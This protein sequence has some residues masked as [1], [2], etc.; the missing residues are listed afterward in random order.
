[1]KK[2][3]IIFQGK[4][5]SIDKFIRPYASTV[6]VTIGSLTV[7]SSL[8]LSHFFTFNFHRLFCINLFLY[9]S[10]LLGPEMTSLFCVFIH[11]LICLCLFVYLYLYLCPYVSISTSFAWFHPLLCMY[12]YTMSVSILSLYHLTVFM[13]SVDIYLNTTLVYIKSIHLST[14]IYLT[15]FCICANY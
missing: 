12:V 8:L 5:T 14:P 15:C 2:L 9:L 7:Y 13:S 3:Y 10:K 6:I 4:A 11:L 1:M